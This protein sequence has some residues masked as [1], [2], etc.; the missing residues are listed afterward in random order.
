MFHKLH[1]PGLSAVTVYIDGQA[2]AAEAGE[3]VAAVLLRQP[4]GWS[5]TTPISESPRAP[6]C[7]M[8]VCFECLV[9]ID[10]KGS[11]QGCL[12]PVR[13][14]MSIIRHMGVRRLSA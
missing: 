13:E 5:R 6:Y 2:V 11:V 14:G 3:S 12:T 7:M 1:D 9:E 8:G 10:G 4:A